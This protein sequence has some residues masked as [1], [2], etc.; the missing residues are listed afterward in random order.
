MKI[1]KTILA[2]QLCLVL[3]FLGGYF[4][5]YSHLVSLQ[6]LYYHYIN[7]RAMVSKLERDYKENFNQADVARN[8]L[9][10]TVDD[11]EQS[12][13]TELNFQDIQKTVDFYTY[14]DN[15]LAVQFNNRDTDFQEMLS[16]DSQALKLM[17]P[18]EYKEFYTRRQIA[19][20]NDYAAF[21]AYRT[22]ME[23]LITGSIAYY[24]Y[25][26]LY[27]IALSSLLPQWDDYN[28]E[29]FY[30]DQSN[31]AIVIAK[32]N[33]DTQFNKIQA[34]KDQG[35]YN[36]GMYTSM[37]HQHVEIDLLRQL[38]VAY[39]SND[40]AAIAEVNN[41]IDQ[42]PNASSQDQAIATY[43]EWSKEKIQPYFGAQ[44]TKHKA[45]GDLYTRAYRYAQSQKL[46]DILAVWNNQPPVSGGSEK[47]L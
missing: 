43:L 28:N 1:T 13:Q 36:D 23:E 20:E 15:Q 2:L 14:Y 25:S 11:M 46:H 18:T 12:A 33:F 3:V 4:F 21:T 39:R 17:L 45:S 7:P 30:S 26:N 10:L 27:E 5:L 9:N 29:R 37:A 24:T 42:T 38:Y 22:G 35:V 32:A 41:K 19:D 40:K 6:D 34:L 16:L 8:D 44:D 31:S 47:T